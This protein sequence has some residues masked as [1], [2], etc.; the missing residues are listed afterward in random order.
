MNKQ[1]QHF[2]TAVKFLVVVIGALLMSVG[3][4]YAATT[5]GTNINTTG[6]T[7]LG[8]GTGD[9]VTINGH[10]TAA[11]TT[12][13]LVVGI[14]T[15]ATPTSSLSVFGGLHVFRGVATTSDALWVGSAGT[16]SQLD[17]AGGDLYVQNDAEIDNNLFVQ[18]YASTTGDLIV[19][20]GTI[21]LT[22]STATTTVGIF[23]RS[24]TGGVATSTLGAGDL[25]DGTG[26]SAGCLELVMPDG[27]YGHCYLPNGATAL[28]CARG[29]CVPR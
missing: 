10:I 24:R 19:K 23:A 25:D 2:L 9:T 1:G 13:N 3:I 20:G 11:T 17:L 28:V 29:Q 15:L 7:T 22:T 5:I 26:V 12:G 14:D 4:I 6:T 16:V 27:G 8:D 18:G 21:D